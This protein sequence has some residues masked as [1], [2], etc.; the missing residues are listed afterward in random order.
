MN[1]DNI[2]YSQTL[3]KSKHSL[4]NVGKPLRIISSLGQEFLRYQVWGTHF[5]I[6]NYGYFMYTVTEK[7]AA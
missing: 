6:I 4:D 2:A 7:S 1:A 5:I 3:F